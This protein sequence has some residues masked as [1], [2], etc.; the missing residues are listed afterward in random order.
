MKRS[1]ILA[2]VYEDAAGMRRSGTIDEKAMREFD[3][4]AS[5]ALDES[6][7]QRMAK[8]LTVAMEDRDPRV[9][10]T[11]LR[12]V[13]EV[14]GLERATQRLGVTS[15]SLA[16]VV[17]PKARPSF[18]E[19]RAVVS[20]LGFRLGVAGRTTEKVKPSRGRSPRSAVDVREDLQLRSSE[21]AQR[22]AALGG[23]APK[24]KPV[25]RRRSEAQATRHRRSK[26]DTQH[27]TPADRSVLL[28]LAA[29]DVGADSD[30]VREW[31]RKRLRKLRSPITPGRRSG[32]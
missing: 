30:S 19:V 12:T 2:E 16:G 1:R 13:I 22:L 25:P 15:A 21:G 23:S 9:F 6:A 14:I 8:E 3:A 18:E 27:I 5:P 10:L 17:G 28:D 4:L 26:H 29:S 31:P 32:K 24:L 20:G 11:A 7:W